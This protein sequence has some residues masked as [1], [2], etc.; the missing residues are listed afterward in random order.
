M[1]FDRRKM[2]IIIVVVAAFVI[3]AIVYFSFFYKKAGTATPATETG[4]LASTSVSGFPT[5]AVGTTTPGSRPASGNYNVAAETPHKTDSD[6]L[7]KVAMSFVQRFGTY[8]TQSDYGNF[9]DLEIMMTPSMRSWSESY[10]SD[11][12]KQQKNNSYYGIT[13]KALTYKVKSY[14]EKSGQTEI[15]VSTQR[16]DSATTIG[17]GQPYIQD[18]TVELAKENGE[19]LFDR[20]VWGDKH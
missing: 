15:V 2:G 14:D 18:I 4:S 9:T 5:A 7:G 3:A 16:S 11:L 13:T 1:Q 8:S 17:G 20:A 10:V 12:K 6:D 19:W